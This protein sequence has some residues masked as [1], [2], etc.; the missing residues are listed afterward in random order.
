M[1]L[2]S[3]T[4]LIL[5][6][7]CAGWFCPQVSA[8]VTYSVL[9]PANPPGGPGAAC[10]SPTIGYLAPT[11]VI[12]TCYG[13]VWT[14][15]G[16][17]GGANGTC[18]S[19]SSAPLNCAPAYNTVVF[20][21]TNATATYTASSATVDIIN[22]GTLA[23][24][25]TSNVVNNATNGEIFEVN[26][27]QAASGGPYTIA[28]PTG[29]PTIPVHPL[30]SACVT[31]TYQYLNSSN[32]N[33]ISVVPQGTAPG[34]CFSQTIVGTNPPSGDYFTGCT[35]TYPQYWLDSSGNTWSPVKLSGGNYVLGTPASMNAANVTNVPPG[36]LAAAT[37]TTLTDGATVTYAIGSLLNAIASLTFT[38]HSGSRTLNITNPVIGGNYT[39]ELVQDG[40]GGEGLTLGTGCTWVVANNGGGA[41]TLTNAA[42][43]RDVLVFEYDGTRCLTNL[44]P[45]LN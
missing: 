37:V 18:L 8:Q 35:S 6:M 13:G 9:I 14:A 22:Y 31:A 43:A 25:I 28:S 5:A 40:T 34:V 38:V 4:L 7:A 41:V 36:A 33:L 32:I 17:G 23:A 3:S 24:S 2:R 30:A 10:S 39:V 1:T 21:N 11:G 27:C 44:L 45:H 15:G 42:N 20:T 29:W 12:Y 16:G 26:S 19:P